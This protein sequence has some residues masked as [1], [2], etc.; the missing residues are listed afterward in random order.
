MVRIW[1]AVLLPLSAHLRSITHSETVKCNKCT[2]QI[3]VL[4]KSTWLMRKL[5]KFIKIL[6]Q[7]DDEKNLSST[8]HKEC[9]C[10][11][12]YSTAPNS[13]VPSKQKKIHSFI[14]QH[15]TVHLVLITCACVRV[16]EIMWNGEITRHFHANEA[17]LLFDFFAFNKVLCSASCL[18]IQRA[19]HSSAAVTIVQHRHHLI[20]H[21][22]SYFLCFPF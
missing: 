6:N 14:H 9:Q 13:V 16:F 8:E 19:C 3:C 18:R 22:V 1:Y 7:E 2:G 20:H 5:S 17:F 15:R 10:W 21:I 4:R 12:S 11:N